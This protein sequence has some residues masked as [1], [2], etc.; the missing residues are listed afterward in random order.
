MKSNV[1]CAMYWKMYG[2]KDSTPHPF[3]I[4]EYDTCVS[5]HLK[6]KTGTHKFCMQLSDYY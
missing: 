6:F 3:R 2:N 1:M 5:R 4:Y